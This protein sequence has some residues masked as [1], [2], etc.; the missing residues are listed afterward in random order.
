MDRDAV[1]RAGRRAQAEEA[2]A[3][4]RE[5]EAALR[6]QLAELVLEEEADRVDASAFAALDEDDVRLVRAALGQ[7][8]EDDV[9][10]EDPFAEDLYVVF[11]DEP[12][13]QDDDEEDEPSRLLREI[14]G[15]L[16]TQ[17]A[18]ERFIAALETSA[19]TEAQ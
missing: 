17:A 15:S 18:L 13:A 3:F 12:G 1:A 16:R 5:R 6:Q 9:D 2:L 8:D 19:A 4:E 11:D 14:E 10:E 7:V